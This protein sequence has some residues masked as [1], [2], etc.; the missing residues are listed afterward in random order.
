MTD[1]VKDT[2]M[3]DTVKKLVDEIRNRSIDEVEDAL[4]MIAD[5]MATGDKTDDLQA[6]AIIDGIRWGSRAAVVVEMGGGAM[7]RAIRPN[8]ARITHE[9]SDEHAA[10]GA[11]K[12]ALEAIQDYGPLSVAVELNQSPEWEITIGGPQGFSMTL[13]RVHDKPVTYPN[14]LQRWMLAK[15]FGMQWIDLRE[16][17]DD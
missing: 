6:D 13:N 14:R 8:G 7:L 16:K 1:D 3:K 9:W 12:S 2:T 5:A 11:I 15:F 17:D 4:T 10:D